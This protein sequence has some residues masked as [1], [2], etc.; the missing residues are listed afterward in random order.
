MPKRKMEYRVMLHPAGEVESVVSKQLRKVAKTV[1]NKDTSNVVYRVKTVNRQTNPRK[2]YV[3]G[4][5]NIIEA[6]LFPHITLSQKIVINEEDEGKIAEKLLEIVKSFKPF[7]L[8]SSEIGDYGEDFTIYLTFADNK[9]VE[10]LFSDVNLRLK[11]FFDKAREK[12]DI[13]HI[14]L[15]YDD[16]GGENIEKA[17]KVIKTN[18]LVN[19]ELPI[20]SLWLWRN[21]DGWKPFK[22]FE[23]KSS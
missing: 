1:F 15:L 13:L 23:F 5:G 14:S 2:L 8:Y 10:R 20:S 16:T 6:E 9:E 17:R 12:R 7:T 19:K 11:P 4:D 21:K 18:T 3:K 22:E